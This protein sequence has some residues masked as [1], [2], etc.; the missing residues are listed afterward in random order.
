MID[1]H[2]VVSLL[3]NL[4]GTFTSPHLIRHLF[5]ILLT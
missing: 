3:I 2:M 1:I 5:G 4:Y